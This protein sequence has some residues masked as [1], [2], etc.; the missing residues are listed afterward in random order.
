MVTEIRVVKQNLNKLKVAASKMLKDVRPEI[1][2]AINETSKKL[3]TEASTRIRETLA[4]K[5]KSVDKKLNRKIANA[6][7]LLGKLYISE[8]S[9]GLGNFHTSQTKAGV[10]AKIYKQGSMV[11][12]PNAWGPKTKLKP[13]VY[14]RK[15][16]ASYPII[17]VPAINFAEEVSRAG[18]DTLIRGRVKEILKQQVARRMRLMQLRAAGKV[19]ESGRSR[20]GGLAR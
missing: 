11:L 9:L 3:R 1:A 6:R 13:Y 20:R 18:V 8:K 17:T 7:D 4:V 19:P 10:K 5:K 15:N 12:F 14:K 16:K 2:A